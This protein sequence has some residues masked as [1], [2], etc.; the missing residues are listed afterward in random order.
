MHMEI[1][2]YIK[3]RMDPFQILPSQETKEIVIEKKFHQ[4]C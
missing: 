3:I 4:K 2:I 1:F